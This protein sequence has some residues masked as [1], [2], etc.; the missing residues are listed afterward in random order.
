MIKNITYGIR[1][2]VK[3][4]LNYW[5]FREYRFRRDA[6]RHYLPSYS[7]T[8]APAR[9]ERPLIICMFDGKRYQGG[10]A[11]RLRGIMTTYKFCKDN[12]LDFRIHFVSPFRLEEYLEPNEYDWRI[13]DGD[14][15][16]NRNDSLPVNIDT[17][18][19]DVAKDLQ[20]Q[21]KI[22][23]KF[24]LGGIKKY[25]QIHVYTRTWYE[26]AHFRELFAELFRPT[27]AVR[28]IVDRQTAALDNGNFIS[29]STRFL[30]LLGD[31][32]EKRNRAAA[33]TGE[34]KQKMLIE[35]C[36]SKIDEIKRMHPEV[37]KVLVTSDSSKFL[38]AA[39]ERYSYVYV[40][41]G[42]T[43]HIDVVGGTADGESIYMKTFVDFLTLSRS[44]KLYLIA[45]GG[46][47]RRSGFA[48]R[49]AQIGGRPFER[50]I[51]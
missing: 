29:V 11:D 10:L 2:F 24:L 16:F 8:A 4:T 22:T 3:V 34:E 43:G 1:Y 26:E 33:G 17:A 44:K 39:R 25:R 36:L 30:E 31:F 12:G 37:N 23:R 20:F 40:I 15:S 9:N 48:Q 41:P 7:L 49:A 47:Y 6:R 18:H 13:A 42:K 27:A 50:I 35:R 28:E 5:L 19:I 46:M 38:S 14:V 32:S 21:K 51:F 45:T